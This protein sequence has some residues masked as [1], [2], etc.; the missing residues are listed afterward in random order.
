MSDLRLILDVGITLRS[1]VARVWHFHFRVLAWK[2]DAR[3][4]F[5]GSV[6][7]GTS[8]CTLGFVYIKLRVAFYNKEAILRRMCMFVNKR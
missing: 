3:S 8:V 4:L 2:C 1:K 5:F 7:G 6:Q